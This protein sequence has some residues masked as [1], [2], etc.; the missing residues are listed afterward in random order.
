M[1]AILVVGMGSLAFS[2]SFSLSAVMPFTFLVLAFISVPLIRKSSSNSRVKW[3]DRKDAIGLIFAALAC[4]VLL[5]PAYNRFHHLNGSAVTAF[6]AGN[7]DDSAHIEALNDRLQYNQVSFYHTNLADKVRSQSVERGDYPIGWEAANAAVVKAAAPSLRPG[8]ASLKAY[9]ATKFIWFF[10]LVFFFAYFAAWIFETILGRGGNRVETT[11]LCIL[12]LLFIFYFVFDVFRQGFFTFIPQLL[13]LPLCVL[14]LTAIKTAG[15]EQFWSIFTVAA[16]YAIGGGLS[17][18]LVLPVLSLI[19][20]VGGFLQL[21]DLGFSILKQRLFYWKLLPVLP[22]YCLISL[23]VLAQLWMA[24][25]ING[26]SGGFL[27]SINQLGAIAQYNQNFYIIVAIG[28]AALAVYSHRVKTTPAAVR[29]SFLVA[30][31]LLAVAL[32]VYLVQIF[33]VER[34]DYYYFKALSTF[35]FLAIP[36]AIAGYAC[37]F[38][39]IAAQSS[40][41]P[42]LAALLVLGI[43][44]FAGVPAGNSPTVSYLKG[45]LGLPVPVANYVYD[46]IAS[47][48]AAAPAQHAFYYNSKDPLETD[49]A[50]MLMKT[51]PQ[52]HDCYRNVRPSF[53]DGSTPA[54]IA[55][56]IK[57]SCSGY[58]ITIATDAQ[59]RAELA[60]AFQSVKVSSVKLKTIP[61]TP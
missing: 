35:T 50:N 56:G 27:V 28:L 33:S 30:T 7:V 23:A 11:L 4:L 55:R 8:T 34:T 45:Q 41:S 22:L 51:M 24:S 44:F 29:I 10:M 3:A 12:I 60:S 57:A 48:H 46:N 52:E 9:V 43:V 20:V 32:L 13:C 15:W 53:Y 61:V 14:S 6:V 42:I 17:W 40:P 59:T 25:H 19:L 31:S 1:F 49:I 2:R 38:R 5:L 18:L 26:I 54:A 47:L 58:S 36:L 39:H 37:L 16:V 21:K